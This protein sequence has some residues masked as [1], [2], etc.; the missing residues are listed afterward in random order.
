MPARVAVIG[1]GSF[2]SVM[3]RVIADGAAASPER[4]ESTVHWW[5]RREELAVE[6]NERR[7]N[8]AYLGAGCALPNNLC[9]STD[10]DAVLAGAGVVVL[11]VP[12]Q[13]LDELYPK[14]RGRLAPGAQILSLC[15]GLHVEE[16]RIVPLSE[17]IGQ[18]TGYATSILAGPNLYTEMALDLFAEAT[19]GHAADNCGAEVLQALCTTESFR[20]ELVDDMIGV[21]LCAAMKNCVAIASGLGAAT[22]GNTRAAIIRHGGKEIAALCAEF[23]PSVNPTTFGEACG[24]GDLMLTCSVGRGQKLAAAFAAAGGQRGW[25]DLSREMLG[26]MQLPDLHNLKAVGAFLGARGALGRY[27]LLAAAHRVAFEGAPPSQVVAALRHQGKGSPPAASP[28]RPT[29]DLQGR[30]ALVVGGAGGIGRAVVAKLLQC[31]ARVLVLDNNAEALAQMSSEHGGAAV[32]T[33]TLDLADMEAAMAAVA[34]AFEH[35]EHGPI[36]YVVHAA[37]LA[38]FEPIAQTSL[39]E[40]DRQYGAN[41][42]PNIYLTQVVAKALLER[43]LPGAVVHI[44]SQSSTL[45]LAEHL[46]YSSSKA[47]VDHVAR[48]QALELGPHGIRVNSVRPTVVATPLALRAWD[49]AKLEEMRASIPL[50]QLATPDDVAD[51]C[52]WL[53]SDRAAM[54]TGAAL[55]VDGGRSMGGSGL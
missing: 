4:F 41:V 5:V 13:F 19:I 20:V 40:F 2:G 17:R 29:I 21:D 50:R 9:A 10:L 48:I 15:K 51:A 52:V 45:P 27:P 39:G 16:G 46:V 38:K 26:G 34:A 55:P 22:M 23:F 28:V 53:L 6:I 8:E 43:G 35:P 44:S 25:E 37:G 32:S 24:I 42:K 18:Q 47:A 49:P 3:A 11:G 14:M 12:H 33:L 1:G 7:T 36:R 30:R 54:V 31:N